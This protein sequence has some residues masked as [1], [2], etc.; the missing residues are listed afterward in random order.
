[1]NLVFIGT[2]EQYGSDA[3]IMITD[4]YSQFKVFVD[5]VNKKRKW[6]GF[7]S[8]G[9]VTIMTID[10]YNN[11]YAQSKSDIGDMKDSGIEGFFVPNFKG[12]IS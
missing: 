5:G 1:V 8:D 10:E 12:T 7:E 2:G 11:W 4:D 3:D 9:Y 6:E